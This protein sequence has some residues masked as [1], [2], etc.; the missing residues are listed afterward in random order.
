MFR[1]LISVASLAG[2]LLAHQLP[3]AGL[4]FRD[5]RHRL[6][7]EM[8]ATTAAQA[9]QGVASF[10]GAP[11]S[12]RPA[13][14]GTG[15]VPV[16]VGRRLILTLADRLSPDPVVARHS[17]EK[18]RQ[19]SANTWL[20]QA[21]TVESA[22][23]AGAAL[24]RESG[25]LS[26]YPGFRRRSARLNGWSVAPNDRYFDRQTYLDNVVTTPGP[27]VAGNDLVIRSAWS[28]TRG[29]G[30]VVAICDDGMDARHP[31][32]APNIVADLQR[33]FFTQAPSAAHSS[34]RQ[35]HG[36]A[37]AGIVAA[38]DG[39]EIGIAGTAPRAAV[40][41][42]VLF[43]RFDSLVEVEAL[44]ELFEYAQD[45]VAVQNHSWGNADFEP[46]LISDLEANAL[47]NAATLGR[48]GRG[49][50]H[51]RS[52]GNARSTD[53][54]GRSGVGDANLDGF[55]NAPWAITV[56]AVRVDGRVASYSTPGACVLVSALGGE[57]FNATGLFSLDPLGNDGFN[58]VF[59]SGV[60]LADYIYPGHGE[61]GTSFTSPQIA[62]LAAL[63]LSAYPELSAR[64]VSLV[65]ALAARPLAFDPVTQT[66]GAG[67][68][69]G[70]N[71]GF[72]V[73]HAGRMLELARRLSP[74][75]RP[76]TVIRVPFHQTLEIPDD[77]FRIRGVSPDGTVILDIP[78]S[79]G[80]SAL[81][82][83]RQGRRVLGPLYRFTDVGKAETALTNDLRGQIALAERRPGTF[84]EKLNRA[85]DAGA[86]AGIIAD[87]LLNV[88]RT[89]MLRSEFA[90]IP[91][92][93]IHKT[94]GDAL[95]SLLAA[96]PL[97][98]IQWG[99]RSTQ[100]E[101][102]VTHPAA[103]H[104]VQVFTR[105]SHPRQGDLRISLTSPAGT[106]S[107]L[108]RP[109]TVD[110]E[111]LT[112]WTYGSRQFLLEPAL[113]TWVLEFTDE[114]PGKTGTVTEVELILHGTP[115]TSDMDAD[116]L[117]DDW[118]ERRLGGLGRNA[119]EDDDRDGLS[120]AAEQALG[121]N[122]HEVDVLPV[123]LA[124]D[125]PGQFRIRWPALNGV[126]YLLESGLSVTGPFEQVGTLPGRAP[127]GAWFPGA[128]GPQKF[129]RIRRSPS[130]SPPGTV[131][132]E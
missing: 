68:L 103:V 74:T 47:S 52:A 2:W 36:T 42:W 88:D 34:T 130:V 5:G 90:R 4:E 96:D 24:S 77:G 30:V 19:L 69:T 100:V 85:A 125:L 72:G 86:V 23:A 18:V 94:D 109:S 97:A 128:I 123:E 10:G 83:T 35:Y 8:P 99:R 75:N 84:E 80:N 9:S 67:L 114:S 29:E 16:W 124:R 117:A 71:V 110:A 129:F 53:Y 27:A 12:W 21:P 64:D 32:L 118:E 60:E 17:L 78:A 7:V 31:E 87:D 113:G 108:Q 116:G 79:G 13:R 39:N 106:V 101:L 126:D 57:R 111:Q 44:A 63:M 82:D 50:V 70:D 20:V 38:R 28:Q 37:V 91:G 131:R 11:D 43:D 132:S 76:W 81:L 51:V 14:L 112:S 46:L 6:M 105:L 49:V 25:V 59:G 115:L 93:F 127:E 58:T 73:P 98:R 40:C 45:R 48:Q 26:A 92:A 122:P 61:V 41:G 66:N 33:N 3:A 15:R 95:R 65:L 22:L 104:W 89:L 62:G 102:V 119:D 120:L 56:G 1:S 54:L 121:T 107:L 55:A